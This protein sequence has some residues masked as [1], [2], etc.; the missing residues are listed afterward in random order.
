MATLPKTPAGHG[1]A[2][3]LAFAQNDPGGHG[4]AVV[5]VFGGQ[6]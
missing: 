5:F 4:K 1:E 2:A 3:L 6:K